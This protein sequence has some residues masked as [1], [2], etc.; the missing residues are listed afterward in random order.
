M[1]IYDDKKDKT[2]IIEIDDSTIE[3]NPDL[4]FFNYNNIRN[5]WHSDEKQWYLLIIDVVRFLTDSKDPK[6]YIKKIRQ[7]DKEL[8][9]SGVQ[10]VPHFK[11]LL[12]TEK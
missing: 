7:R 10:I 2:E 6:Q 12:L 9:P 3:E 8:P 1:Y 11:C 5:V 4:E